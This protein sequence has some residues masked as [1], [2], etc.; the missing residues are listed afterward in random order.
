MRVILPSC[1]VKRSEHHFHLY[2]LLDSITHNYLN[3]N[4]YTALYVL[5]SA[6]VS[7]DCFCLVRMFKV[8]T[9][10]PRYSSGALFCVTLA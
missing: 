6:L 3:N 4:A 7:L 5:Q 1:A 8:T 9:K 2:L 10:G